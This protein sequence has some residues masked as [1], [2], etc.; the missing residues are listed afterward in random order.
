MEEK[1]AE[2]FPNT[3]SSALF[4]IAVSLSSS[5]VCSD[6]VA[7]IKILYSSSEFS[8]VAIIITKDILHQ[9]K[10]HTRK[11]RTGRTRK[12]DVAGRKYFQD[13]CFPRTSKKTPMQKVRDEQ[14]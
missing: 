5:R 9:R 8:D 1:K 6:H 4:V 7:T 14:L 3:I 11:L 2:T 13:G 12:R 10:P